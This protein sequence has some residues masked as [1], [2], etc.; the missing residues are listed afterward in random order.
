MTNN[1][2]L[3][4]SLSEEEVNKLDLLREELGMNR[5]QYIRYVLSGQHKILTP[6]IKYKEL[7][8]RLAQIDLDL[9]VIALKDTI[10][11]EETLAIFC[12]IRKLRSLL[13]MKGTSGQHD[14][15]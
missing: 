7:V 6:S 9:R 5:S 1:K 4:L 13:D 3:F 10:S 2:R 14:Q 12:E 8:E 11:P 15:K